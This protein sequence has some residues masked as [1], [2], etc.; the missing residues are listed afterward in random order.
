MTKLQVIHSSYHIVCNHPTVGLSNTQP[1]GYMWPAVYT[2][3]AKWI[4]VARTI[5]MTRGKAY[6]MG[7]NNLS[8]Y[9]TSTFIC[10]RLILLIT[11]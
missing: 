4:N 9:S 1:A 3:P 5:L 2:Q 7:L 10:H 8:E 6:T 11:V